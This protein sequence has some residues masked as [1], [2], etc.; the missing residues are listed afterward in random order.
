M[1]RASPVL[2]APLAVL[3]LAAFTGEHERLSIATDGTEGDGASYEAAASASGKLVVFGS[4]ASNLVAGDGNGASDIFLRD[5]RAETTTLLSAD[6]GGNEGNGHSNDPCISASGRWVLFQSNASDLAAG[7]ENSVYDVFLLDRKTG[8]MRILSQAE[9]G[10]P[11]NGHSYV[12]GASLSANGRYAT[13]YSD[14]TNLVP[15]D[16]N[17]RVD[18]FFVDVKTGRISL[19]SGAQDGTFGDGDSLDPSLSPNGRYVAFHSNSTDLVPGVDNGQYQIYE[20]DR[21]TGALHHA[22]PSFLGGPGNDDSYDPVVSSNGASVAFY[23]DATDLSDGADT[24]SRPDVFLYDFRT[25]TMTRLSDTTEGNQGTG[26]SYECSISQSGRLVV[27]YT[28]SGLLAEDVNG[29]YDAY[30]YDVKIGILRMISKNEDGAV[31]DGDSY[32]FSTCLTPSGRWM[33][34]STAASNLVPNDAN[35]EYDVFLVDP[36]R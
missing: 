12:Y 29:N 9:D 27:F 2:V 15:G 26:Y 17:N 7:D 22:S 16:L 23:S 6:S 28:D 25:G 35:G 33:V 1:R 5:R 36:R 20:W 31:G 24:N 32:V 21:K 14:A 3:A 18:V 34:Y 8:E 30:A 10:T 13:F 4:F 19:V 11:G